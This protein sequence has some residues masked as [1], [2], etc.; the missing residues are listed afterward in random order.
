M[1]DYNPTIML[2]EFYLATVKIFFI[3]MCITILKYM[4]V[5]KNIKIIIL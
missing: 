3:H 5:L 2:I 4:N 1:L